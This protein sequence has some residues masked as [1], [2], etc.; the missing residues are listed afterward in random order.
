[1]RGVAARDRSQ[2]SYFARAIAD[3]RST[4]YL[5]YRLMIRFVQWTAVSGAAAPGA[6]LWRAALPL[7]VLADIAVWRVLRRNQRFGLGWRLLL[8]A[9]D[10]AFWSLSPLP[11][12]RSYDNAVLVAIPLSI[13]A[14]FKIGALGLVVPVALLGPTVGA[15]ILAGLPANPFTFA[16]LLM[17]L[18]LGMALFS[19]CGRLHRQAE[20]E[21]TQQQAAESRRAFMFGQNSVAMGADSV[22]DAIEGVVPVLGR[23]TEGSALWQ[24]ADGW[25][26]RLAA[27]TAAQAAY[28]QVALL[29]WESGHNR[30]PDLSA[31]V[32]IY[33]SEGIGTAVLTGR[34]V[35]WLHAL[36][37]D[38]DLRGRVDVGLTGD[39]NGK[40]TAGMELDLQ[41]GP[42]QLRVP[43]DRTATMRPVDTGPVT[44]GLIGAQLL[45][46]LSPG[47]GGVPPL[48][49]GAGIALCVVTAW[50]THRQLMRRG[51]AARPTILV[52]AMMVAVLVTLLTCPLLTVMVSP[53]GDTVYISTGLMVLAFL[54]GMYWHGLSQ[55]MRAVV[56]G[57]T[58]LTAGLMFVLTPGPVSL[59]SF[60]AGLAGGLAPFPT[61]RYISRSLATAAERNLAAAVEQAESAGRL[62]FSEGQQSVLELVGLARDDAR[63]QL[64]AVA[65]SLEPDLTAKITTR[66]EEVDR[67]LERLAHAE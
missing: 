27:D 8:D 15:R 58:C 65:V 10:I 5:S 2:G 34:Q 7:F 56:V 46:L 50:W 52:G 67:R 12:S 14:G 30:H 60:L 18:G 3:S 33:M 28:L 66:L 41:V 1:M 39:S 26:A 38:C 4:L 16:W 40:R 32:E 21:A 57:A 11:I 9:A 44:Y 48:A 54:G 17:G 64:A 37:E 35:G 63:A 55:Q 25:K 31:Q 6:G 61:C 47:R 20:A 13:E 23:P 53:D 22:V 43:A 24:L 29:G 49:V 45:S 36:L 59:R 51:L 42:R 19:Y 62:A